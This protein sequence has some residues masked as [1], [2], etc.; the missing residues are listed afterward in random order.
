MSIK[1]QSGFTLIEMVVAI[2]IIGVG[3]A[4]V[5]AAY[6]SSVRSSADAV[7]GK[8]MVAIA[9]EMMEEV[10]LKPY[11]STLAAGAGTTCGQPAANRSAFDDVGD[12]NGYQT[13]GICDGDGI[14]VPGLEGYGV[15]VAVQVA[16]LDGIANALR[17]TVTA[18]HGTQTFVLDGFRTDY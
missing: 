3:V 4:G 12:Y 10:L 18:S 5:L 1:R 13:A 15:V 17:V 9:E 2:V 8:Q 7:V 11:S 14:A 6:M 16:A